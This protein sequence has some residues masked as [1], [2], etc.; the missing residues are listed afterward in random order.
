ME[1]TSGYHLVQPPL[2]NQEHLELVAQDH[3]ALKQVEFS[4]QLQLLP[5]ELG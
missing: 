4:F 3:V 5:L 2:L 1:G